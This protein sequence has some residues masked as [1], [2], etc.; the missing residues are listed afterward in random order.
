MHQCVCEYARRRAF[1]LGGVGDGSWAVRGVATNALDLAALKRAVMDRVGMFEPFSPKS[2]E[3]IADFRVLAILSR[4]GEVVEGV[5]V[6]RVGVAGPSSIETES[7]LCLPRPT[8]CSTRRPRQ[9]WCGYVRRVG[10]QK[11]GELECKTCVCGTV[12]V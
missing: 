11:G 10:I 7:V 3:A 1:W 8:L 4:S 6:L 5:A 2:V 12:Y 9:K